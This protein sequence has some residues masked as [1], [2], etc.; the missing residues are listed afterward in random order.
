MG[1][2]PEEGPGALAAVSGGMTDTT[3]TL[4]TETGGQATDEV[5]VDRNVLSAG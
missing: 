3:T 2:V 5:A 1:W 4:G